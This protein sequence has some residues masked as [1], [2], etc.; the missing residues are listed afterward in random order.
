MVFSD[1]SDQID[2]EENPEAGT[3]AE[4]KSEKPSVVRP[5]EYYQNAQGIDDFIIGY[6]A[7]EDDEPVP[8]LTRNEINRSKDSDFVV[9]VNTIEDVKDA[10]ENTEPAEEAKAEP[11]AEEKAEPVA[12]AKTDA[13]DETHSAVE[14]LLKELDSKV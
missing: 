3:E 5:S 9:G 13:K 10:E 11:A 8:Y 6:E 14:D 2:T 1:D 4:E 7:P 12:E